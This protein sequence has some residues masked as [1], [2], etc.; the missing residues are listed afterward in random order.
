MRNIL[1]HQYLGVDLTLTWEVVANH[2]PALKQTI[3]AIAGT[4]GI[5]LNQVDDN[6][7]R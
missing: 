7:R 6:P 1:A 4:M 2:L 3:I 5:V